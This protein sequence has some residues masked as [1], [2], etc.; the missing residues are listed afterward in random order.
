MNR[1]PRA[2]LLAW[3][4]PALLTVCATHAHAADA[5]R[6]HPH[7]GVLKPYPR[8]PPALKLSESERKRLDT[9]KTVMRLTEGE[10]GGRGMAIFKVSAAPDVTWA[11]IRDFSS[12]PKWIDEVEKCDVYRQDGGKIDVAF[13]IKSFPITVDYFIHHDYDIAGRWGTW[14]LDYTRESDLDDNVGFWRVSPV[15]GHPDQSIV[16]YSV[17]I[18]LRGWVPAFV[19]ELLVDKGLKQATSWVKLQ[20]EQRASTRDTST[21][22]TSTRVTSPH[23]M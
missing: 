3:I 14:T 6:P 15:D 4:L 10:A 2:M 17:D 18:K 19:R 21:R 8:P 1:Q 7:R 16:E 9:G 23:A 11:T 13:R 22:D 12:Y 20:S 5:A